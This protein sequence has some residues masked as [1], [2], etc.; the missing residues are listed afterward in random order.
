[1]TI[2]DK[3]FFIF[4]ISFSLFGHYRLIVDGIRNA[5]KMEKVAPKA[6]LPDRPRVG[7]TGRMVP[8]YVDTKLVKFIN[9]GE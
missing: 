5:K 1:M 3:A 8:Y 4:L 2:Q 9:L 7:T 6:V